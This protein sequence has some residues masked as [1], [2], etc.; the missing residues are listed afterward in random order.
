MLCPYCNAVIGIWNGVVGNRN[1]VVVTTSSPV[2]EQVTVITGIIQCVDVNVIAVFE[3]VVA[4]PVVVTGLK[5]F[6]E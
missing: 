6:S 2:P 3:I 1:N 5:I 4:I